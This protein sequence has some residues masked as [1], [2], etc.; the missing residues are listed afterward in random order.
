MIKLLDIKYQINRNLF[1]SIVSNLNT[2][3][4]TLPNKGNMHCGRVLT[5]VISRSR[6]GLVTPRPVGGGQA[7]SPCIK[8]GQNNS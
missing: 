3:F 7:E 6:N 5:I 2:T 8:D 1:D 4:E